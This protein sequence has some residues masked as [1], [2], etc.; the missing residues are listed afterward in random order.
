MAGPSQLMSVRCRSQLSAG[1]W[2]EHK[3]YQPGFCIT[4][5]RGVVV[6]IFLG[7]AAKKTVDQFVLFFDRELGCLGHSRRDGVR[8]R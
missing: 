3:T 8:L 2:M 5:P 4:R 1:E 6:Q 7:G